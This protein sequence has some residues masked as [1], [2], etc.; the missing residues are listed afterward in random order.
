MKN[1]GSMPTII[2]GPGRLEDCHTVNES[3]AVDEYL[4]FILTYALLI[5]NCT[6][7]SQEEM[8]I[9]L[10]RTYVHA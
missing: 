10:E 8:K 5:W 7:G 9:K 1:I 2:C 6:R 4:N 3:V